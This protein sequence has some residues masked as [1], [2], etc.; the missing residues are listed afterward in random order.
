VE[1]QRDEQKSKWL[2]GK[3]GATIYYVQQGEGLRGHCEATVGC[4]AVRVDE[5][6]FV[7]DRWK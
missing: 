7:C 5:A 6:E 1:R 3:C 4:I 2:R